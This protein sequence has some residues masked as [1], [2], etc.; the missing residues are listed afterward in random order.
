MK[1]LKFITL[2]AAIM[3]CGMASAQFINT[4]GNERNNQRQSSN[5]S[6]GG[7]VLGYSAFVEFG[8]SVG[9]GDYSFDRFEITTSHGIQ[10]NSHIFIGLGTGLKYFFDG[11]N[12]AIPVYTDFRVNFLNKKISPFAGMKIGYT[13]GDVSG[14]MVTPMFGCRFGFHNNFGLILSLGYD[15][16]RGKVTTYYY[17]YYYGYNYYNTHT[18]NLGGVFLKIGLEF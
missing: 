3:V 6:G 18:E 14:V 16:Q 9:I 17:N 8:Y 10:A 11:S 5:E 12:Y 7:A 4:G 1:K 13:I 2:L 15:Y